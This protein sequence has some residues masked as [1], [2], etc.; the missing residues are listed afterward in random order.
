MKKTNVLNP[1]LIFQLLFWTCI[2]SK[3]QIK[4]EPKF[5]KLPDCL[6]HLWSQA[7]SEQGPSTHQTLLVG[8]EKGVKL[9]GKTEGQCA[10]LAADRFKN[11]ITDKEMKKDASLVMNK[12]MNVVVAIAPGTN[13]KYIA[14]A[15]KML[16]KAKTADTP[17][18]FEMETIK[19]IIKQTGGASINIDDPV[20]EAAIRA[21]YKALVDAL[22][23]DGKKEKLYEQAFD[24]EPCHNGSINFFVEPPAK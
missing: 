2:H 8:H 9:I 23:T 17:E 19:E 12:A 15:L 16:L 13:L 21:V 11:T 22:I 1:L 6:E 24:R 18:E 3:A 7:P 10:G 20:V 14:I 5:P 4:V